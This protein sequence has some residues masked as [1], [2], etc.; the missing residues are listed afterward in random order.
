MAYFA[1]QKLLELAAARNARLEYVRNAYRAATE[2]VYTVEHILAPAISLAREERERFRDWFG[3]P[4]PRH[5]GNTLEAEIGV[6]D[7]LKLGLAR[8]RD[9]HVTS[10]QLDAYAL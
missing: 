6:W 1:N 2:N 7:R 9:Q 3:E 8:L 10:E 4:M 5:V